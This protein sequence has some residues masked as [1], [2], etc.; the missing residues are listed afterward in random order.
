DEIDDLAPFSMRFGAGLFD[1]IIG[2]FVSALLLS[3]FAFSGANWTTT[4]GILTFLAATAIVSFLYMT[5]SV[6][7]FGKTMGMRL[8]SLEVVDALENEYPTL[9]QAAISTSIYLISMALAGTGFITALFNE[10]RRAAHDLLSG[11]IVVREF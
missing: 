6:G 10:E 9:Q 2:G 3:P 7:F 5:I 4:F 1:L 8:F 11:T